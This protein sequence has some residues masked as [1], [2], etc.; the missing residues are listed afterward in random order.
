LTWDSNDGTRVAPLRHGVLE[1]PSAGVRITSITEAD[2]PTVWTGHWWGQ[3]GAT[4][5]APCYTSAHHRRW[6]L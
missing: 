3:T 6:H 2:E 4:H 5:H 1:R